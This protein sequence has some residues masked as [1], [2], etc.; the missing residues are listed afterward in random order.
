MSEKYSDLKKRAEALRN[1]INQMNY[2]YYVLDNPRVSDAEYDKLMRELK[3]L[4]A[5]CPD[6]I[7]SDSPTMRV[8]GAP[9]EQFKKYTHPTPMLSLD[10][11]LQHE[12]FHDF[13]IRLEKAFNGVL[14]EL[15]VEHKYDGLA[16]ELIYEKGKLVIGA[17]RG[18]GKVG[19]DITPNIKTIRSIPL[20]LEGNFPSRLVVRGEALMYKK[21]FERCNNE[22]IE[23]G[24][25]VF[26]NPRNAAAGSLRNL[27]P[28]I[29][30]RR[31]LRAFI[32]GIG[33]QYTLHKTHS[34]LSE[35]YDYLASLHLPIN[36]HIK[37]FSTAEDII[38]YHHEIEATRDTLPYEIDGLV[39]KVNRFDQQE[40]LGEVTN[41]PRWAIAW[42]FKP[43]EAETMV[44]D[45][46][47][48]VGR[49]G[50]LT[51]VAHLEPVRI[52][53]VIIKKVSL[54][55][56]DEIDRLDIGIGDR[57][58][59]YRAGDVI[60]KISHV[61][62][63]KRPTDKKIKRY[64]LPEH[65][66]VC[67]SAVIPL[68][69]SVHRH[70]TN[71]A[72]PAQQEEAIRY[73]ISR[74][75]MNIDG[76]GAEWVHIFLNNKIIK[77]AADLYALHT[78]RDVL[79]G[80]DRM[81]EKLCDKILAAIDKRRSVPLEKFIIALGVPGV[82]ER[83]AAVLA[84]EF[85]SL[86]KILHASKEQ[87]EALPGLG[88]LLAE[89]IQVYFAAPKNIELINTFIKNGLE[90]INPQKKMSGRLQ[91]KVFVITGTLAHMSRHDAAAL[92]KQHGGR[93]SSSVSKKTDYVICGE[94]PGSK[95]TKAQDLD[96]PIINE[97]QLKDMLHESDA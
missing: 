77:T 5:R 78:Q 32:Y 12:E 91:G 94:N 62:K 93:V 56:Q 82:G 17:T 71:T 35:T 44:N 92:V 66:P 23:T 57:V 9:S 97:E 45:I 67:G 30:A 52:G 47:V 19:E 80:L 11:A 70:C 14:P 85:G 65:C 27:D 50:V 21:D 7:T 29:A 13:I 2:E 46:E 38:R 87:F 90:I 8:G 72:C 41:H 59:V 86:D 28:S 55:N 34:T 51:P 39:I 26:A 3:K 25:H 81:G 83:N 84:D 16:V 37:I 4:E 33:E 60:P 96:I 24:Q 63:E 31:H 68:R 89:A 64:Q 95:L 48:Q 58:V 53:G 74:N 54:F 6:L 40:E 61:V 15:I 22:Q 73:F 79:L 42:K 49:T 10:N 1:T 75:A 20:T 36:P 43:H 88:P 69:G 18:D 76:L